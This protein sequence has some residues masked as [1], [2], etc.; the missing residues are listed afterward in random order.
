MVSQTDLAS[1][2]TWFVASV[3]GH[4]LLRLAWGAAAPKVVVKLNAGGER[5]V[6]AKAVMLAVG[7]RARALPHALPADQDHCGITRNASGNP[8]GPIARA[9]G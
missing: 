8:R 1:F 6:E 5:T 7:A 2:A 3:V 9:Q 4:V